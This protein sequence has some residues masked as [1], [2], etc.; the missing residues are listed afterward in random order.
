M[1]E[2]LRRAFS[3]AAPLHKM[4]GLQAAVE[5]VG[6]DWQEAQNHLGSEEWRSIV[7]GFQDEL[8]AGMNFWGVPCFRLEGPGDHPP[9]D[10]WGQDRLWVIT[11]EIKRR[12]A[13]R[14]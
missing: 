14:P 4:T 6:L 10:V 8:I 9:L 13:Q 3:Q 11:D 5:A 1:G 2:L 7:A 12:V